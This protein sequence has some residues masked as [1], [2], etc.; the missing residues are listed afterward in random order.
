MKFKRLFVCL[1][2]FSLFLSSCSNKEKDNSN[3]T[4]E[5]TKEMK[6]E[7]AENVVLDEEIKNIKIQKNIVD[8]RFLN[9]NPDNNKLYFTYTNDNAVVYASKNLKDDTTDVIYEIKGNEKEN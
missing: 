6:E 1:F 7:T 5:N 4:A 3:S 9:Y 8:F 2:A